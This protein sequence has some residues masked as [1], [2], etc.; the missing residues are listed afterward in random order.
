MF[1]RKKAVVEA[2]EV[3]Q[4]TIKKKTGYID[5]RLLAAAELAQSKRLSSAIANNFRRAAKD[6]LLPDVAMDA[7][8]ETPTTST[9]AQSDYGVIPSGVF[10]WYASQSFIGYQ[11][12]AIMAQH[13]LV[14]KCCTVP[15]RDAIRKGYE[16]TLTGDHDEAQKVELIEKIKRLDKR[17][18]LDKNLVEFVSQGR[19][20]GIR[21]AMFKVDS[22]DKEYYEKPFNIDGITNKSY[23]GIVQIDPYWMAPMLDV[24]AA[25]DP[26]SLG[27]YEPTYWQIMGKSIHKSHLIVMRGPDVPDILKPTYLYGGVSI[28]QKI[29]ERVYAAER[30]AN[31]APQLVMTKRTN[32]LKTDFGGAA[33]NIG[34]VIDQIKSWVMLRD[35]YGIKMIDKENEDVQQFDTALGDLDSV[36]MTQYQLVASVANIPATKLLGVQPKGFNSTGEYEEASYREELEAIQHFDLKPLIERH[37]A[38]M[39]RSEGLGEFETEIVFNPLDSLT[40]VE[41]ADVNLKKAQTDQAL[42]A[43]GAIDGVDIRN[44][45]IA[46]PKSG[47]AG[48]EAAT[49]ESLEPDDLSADF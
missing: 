49:E 6:N 10:A 15:A 5:D 30:T 33:L 11:A 1:W 19:V 31:E 8:C 35:N 20:F 41:Q 3:E 7:A 16:I 9:I 25:S 29:Y 24:A 48:I 36:I 42:Q 37:H 45:I 4:K 2:S 39:I 28:P 14:N 32:I 18:A 43:A 17:F 38:I 13:W 22:T 46:D 34:K 44:R 21:I 40:E 12:M 27:F 26:M 23:K 47:F